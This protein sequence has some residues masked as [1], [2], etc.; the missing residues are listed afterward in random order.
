[1]KRYILAAAA[2]TFC[3]ACE[4]HVAV[5]ETST[6]EPAVEKAPVLE[7]KKV[8]PVV[9]ATTPAVEAPVP[10]A[11]VEEKKPEAAAAPA[12]E[13]AAP[14]DEKKPEAPASEPKP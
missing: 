8:E 2:L 13:P 10:A 5:P 4:Q 9:P 3:V 14:A 11:P 12:A 1:M 7:E 6:T